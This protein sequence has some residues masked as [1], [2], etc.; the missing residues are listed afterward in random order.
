MLL[1]FADNNQKKQHRL[2][3]DISLTKD[4]NPWHNDDRQ[5]HRWRQR[6]QEGTWQVDMRKPHE[7]CWNNWCPVTKPI[8]QLTK[9][10]EPSSVHRGIWW[11]WAGVER[12]WVV[13]Y[14]YADYE[15][16]EKDAEG[17]GTGKHWF[18]QWGMWVFFFLKN[19]PDHGDGD[20]LLVCI[21]YLYKSHHSSYPEC[22][23][24]I[25]QILLCVGGD[26]LFYMF[27]VVHPAR[28]ATQIFDLLS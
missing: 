19:T 12:G 28:S 20:T 18:R 13:A 9:G 22:W 1:A 27:I 14:T 7:G 21:H 10:K 16:S 6:L 17:T 23:P 25:I 11:E 5:R 4:Y 2:K 8:K 24:N 26:D 3:Q 15:R